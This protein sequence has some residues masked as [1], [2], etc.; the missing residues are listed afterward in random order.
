MLTKIHNVFGVG[1]DTLL[2][3]V[4]QALPAMADP[5]R[6]DRGEV[7]VVQHRVKLDR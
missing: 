3:P 2:L 6:F 1:A 4:D 7:R 5:V